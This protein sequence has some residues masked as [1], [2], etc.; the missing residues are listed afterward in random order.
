ML[1]GPPGMQVRPNFECLQCLQCL[2]WRVL[3]VRKGEDQWWQMHGKDE[4]HQKLLFTCMKT[5]NRAL[6]VCPDKDDDIPVEPPKLYA[7]RRDL[8]RLRKRGGGAGV[9]RAGVR[10]L[11]KRKP[12]GRGRSKGCKMARAGVGGGVEDEEATAAAME[13]S[14]T[15]RRAL[16]LTCADGVGAYRRIK[17]LRAM[18]NGSLMALREEDMMAQVAALRRFG[19]LAPL[20]GLTGAPG[21]AAVETAAEWT[22]TEPCAAAEEPV[23]ASDVSGGEVGDPAS[24]GVRE[25]SEACEVEAVSSGGESMG[26]EGCF[27]LDQD[28]DRSES[29]RSADNSDTDS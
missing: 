3:D 2:R 22:D 12:D 21:P 19:G 6:K 14:A 7:V 29:E 10:S 20:R 17:E 18:S 11:G 28:M 24:D 26:P 27:G 5:P 23:V 8:D 13:I 4:E 15:S 16:L 1:T 25:C 9:R